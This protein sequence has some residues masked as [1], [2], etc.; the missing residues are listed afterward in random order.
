MLKAVRTREDSLPSL[1]GGGRRSPFLK[2]E[3]IVKDCSRVRCPFGQLSL[4]SHLRPAPRSTA[5]WNARNRWRS[6]SAEACSV[7]KLERG[8]AA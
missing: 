1:N 2:A 7:R 3:E 8:R 5:R 6:E 4:F